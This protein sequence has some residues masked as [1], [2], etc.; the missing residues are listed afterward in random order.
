MGLAIEYCGVCNYRP[1]AANLAR[2][3][4][5]ATG[6]KAVLIHSRDM[7]ALEVKVDGELIFSKKKLDRFPDPSE[8][9]AVIKERGR[10]PATTG[11][12]SDD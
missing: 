8:I 9:I 10:S 2:A 11:G 3:I 7:G 4:E 5:S 12:I 1:I 6:I